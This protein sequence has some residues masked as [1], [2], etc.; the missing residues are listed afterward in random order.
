MPWRQRERLFRCTFASRVWQDALKYRA[1]A[2]MP[3]MR[4]IHLLR[5]RELCWVW[6]RRDC[7]RLVLMANFVWILDTWTRLF[8]RI[9]RRDGLLLPLVRNVGPTPIQTSIL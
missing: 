9:L 8:K 7:A 2:I 4:R 3:H 6:G 5:R 1:C